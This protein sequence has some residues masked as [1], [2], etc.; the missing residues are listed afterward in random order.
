[1]KSLFGETKKMFCITNDNKLTVSQNGDAA[2]K[3]LVPSLIRVASALVFDA[4]VVP[5]GAYARATIN[6][7]FGEP[8]LI[9]SFEKWWPALAEWNNELILFPSSVD[10]AI[11]DCLQGYIC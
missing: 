7:A 1:M 3:I 6:E 9:L 5:V 4:G 2:A 8:A 10:Y 11:L